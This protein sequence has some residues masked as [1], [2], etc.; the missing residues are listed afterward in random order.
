M[1]IRSNVAQIFFKFSEFFI[2]SSQFH[3]ECADRVLKYLRYFKHLKIQFNFESLNQSQFIFIINSDVSFVDDLVIKHS[4]QNYA[5]QLFEKLINW[6][7]FKQR[8]IT[9]N[10][11][12]IELLIISFTK[13]EHIWWLRFF[14]SINFELHQTLLI[15]CDNAQ[16]IKTFIIN[17]FIIKFR[18]VDVHRHW[19]RQEITKEKIHIQWMPF[20]RIIIDDLI[21][22]LPP[23]RHNEFL[24]LLRLISMK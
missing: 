21:K 2:N 14:E 22:S 8:T 20:I 10:S 4:S 18:H 24:K 13:K 19:L 3:F 12:E 9:I 11:I 16:I 17:H 23:Q 5:F 6:K 7:I 15:Q 1:I